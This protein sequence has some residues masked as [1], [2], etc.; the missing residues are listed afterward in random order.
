MSNLDTARTIGPVE[1]LAVEFPGNNFTGEIL[2]ALADLIE[3]GTVRLIDLVFV[4]KDADGNVAAIEVSG[5]PP[6]AR[7]ML[8]KVS[9]HATDVLNE[10][11]IANV[12]EMLDPNTSVGLL[13]WENAW[14]ARFVET[15]RNADGK[16]LMNVRIPHEVVTEALAA[17]F[18]PG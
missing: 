5:L 15:L 10:E 2:P 4:T 7:A 16:L 12:A 9:G 18:G 17:T 14:A 11:D 6:E 13:V 1:V 3:S 8:E